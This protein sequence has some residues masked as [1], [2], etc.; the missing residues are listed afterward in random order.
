MQA[1]PPAPAVHQHDAGPPVIHHARDAGVKAKAADVIHNLRSC[2]DGPARHVG[3][4]SIDR[5][6]DLDHRSESLNDRQNPA[7]FLFFGDLFASGSR[8][9]T[10]S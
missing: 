9:L 2:L 10:N 7:Q 8:R 1:I 3:A 6:G 5:N 4:I